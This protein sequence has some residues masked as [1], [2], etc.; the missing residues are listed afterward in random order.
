M[1]LLAPYPPIDRAFKSNSEPVFG[2]PVVK[3]STLRED[4]G[5]T[6]SC[7]MC[8]GLWLACYSPGIAFSLS[9]LLLFA[10]HEHVTLS[11][12]PDCLRPVLPQAR[13]NNIKDVP[14]ASIQ[15]SVELHKYYV[16]VNALVPLLSSCLFI[17][18]RRRPLVVWLC[19]A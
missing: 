1:N 3:H 11:K 9:I 5:A 7:A 2:R 19:W 15:T 12:F 8:I 17:P 6:T 10:Q 16:S 18:T 14:W 4:L 13:G